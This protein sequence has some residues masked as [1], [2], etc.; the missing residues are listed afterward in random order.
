[1]SSPI[2]PILL[3]TVPFSKVLPG[4]PCSVDYA[5]RGE[6]VFSR[7]HT[8][9]W[10]AMSLHAVNIQREYESQYWL[11]FPAMRH[12]SRRLYQETNSK[13][14]TL[15]S[16]RQSPGRQLMNWRGMNNPERQWWWWGRRIASWELCGSVWTLWAFLHVID[17]TGAHA[18]SG[19]TGGRFCA[20][21]KNNYEGTANQGCNA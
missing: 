17:N 20:E 9:K 1:M 3:S 7:I 21:K 13:S 11:Q 6:D 12:S 8:W 15:S 16:C 5:S 2:V 19:P 4:L 14:A 18:S 10:A